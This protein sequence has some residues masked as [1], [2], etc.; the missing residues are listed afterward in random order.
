MNG[1]RPVHLLWS[2]LHSKLKMIGPF[3]PKWSSESTPPHV[4]QFTPFTSRV[5][6]PLYPYISFQQDDR[7]LTVSQDQNSGSSYRFLLIL[8]V[9]YIPCNG[10]DALS[11]H[12]WISLT[13]L[14]EFSTTLEIIGRLKDDRPKPSEKLLSTIITVLWYRYWQWRHQKVESKMSYDV[15]VCINTLGPNS[16]KKMLLKAISNVMGDRL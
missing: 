15:Y 3:C 11:N 8:S 14:H 1:L 5:I 13:M 7:F 12:K 9:S 2:I 4:Q 6:A 10:K 16:S